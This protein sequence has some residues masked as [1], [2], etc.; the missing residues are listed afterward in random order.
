MYILGISCYYHDAAACLIKNG[1]IVAAAEEERFTRVKHDNAFP[2]NAIKYCLK[3]AKISANKLSYV[4]FYEKPIVKFERIMQTFTECYPSGFWLFYKTVPSWV[5]EK[6]RIKSIIKRKLH[7]KNEVLFVDHHSSHAASA[8][9]VSP[10]IK[11]AIL[12]VDGVGEWVTASIKTG[13]NNRISNLK[14]IHFPDSLGLLYSTITAFLGFKVNNDEYKVMGLAAYG[15]T[16]YEKEFRKLVKINSDGSFHI[17]M[18]YFDYR[19]KTRMWSDE[20]EKLFGNPRKHD[21]PIEKRHE[22]IAATL[23]KIT[24]EIYFKMTNHV[25]KLTRFENL[26]IAGGVGLNSVANGKLFQKTPFKRIFVQPA[27]TDAGGAIGAA[28]FIW[29]HIL[30]ENRNFEMN[31]AYYGPQFSNDEIF[32]FLRK[33]KIKYKK[34]SRKELL[35][36]VAKAITEDKIV[37]WF[38]G[39]MEVGPRALG[40]RS[41]LA[42]P[43][44]PKMKDIVNNKIKHREDFRPFAGSILI[45]KVNDFFAVPD[46]KHNSP[47]MTFVFDVKDEKR[48]LIPAITHLDGSCRI[49]TISRKENSL[50]YDLI[51][52]FERQTGV[53]VILNTSFNLKGEPIVCTPE[54]AYNDFIKT[55]MDCLVLGSYFVIKTMKD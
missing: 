35:K 46:V 32:G 50:Y 7:F 55:P 22:D 24:E 19:N 39:R 28:Y 33:N 16:K 25:Y 12:T 51:K 38:Q 53:P 48:K 44:N 36:T 49:Q 30:N 41:I 27:A 31:H 5:N 14:E 23:Q 17:D 10:F 3:E 20:F 2:I 29:H 37:G 43:I 21:S 40:N 52:E 15:T 6:L 26:C 54:E 9:F 42:N 18:K 8:F 1:R 4:G 11:A 47:F 45:E 13:E 34:L